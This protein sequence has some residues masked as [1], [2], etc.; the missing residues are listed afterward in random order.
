MVCF[1]REEKVRLDQETRDQE[2]L[3]K[4]LAQQ[5]K[6]E[7]DDERMRMVEQEKLLEQQVADKQR[8]L[9]A[10]RAMEKKVQEEMEYKAKSS[11]RGTPKKVETY[12]DDVGPPAT[13]ANA[14]GV[15]LKSQSAVK[16]EVSPVHFTG[17]K[18]VVLPCE[19]QIQDDIEVTSSLY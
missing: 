7:E 9:D 15:Q 3:R 18:P 13:V 16:T 6:K 5:R 4:R 2:A 17:P 11:P 8:E 10:M 12:E 14:F 1:R 19:E